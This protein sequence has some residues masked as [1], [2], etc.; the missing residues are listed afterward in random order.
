MMSDPTVTHHGPAAQCDVST[1]DASVSNQQCVRKSFQTP[2][3]S[4]EDILG[5]IWGPWQNVFINVPRI[6]V[7]RKEPINLSYLL[8]LVAL[9]HGFFQEPF[10]FSG[11]IE[12]NLNSAC[13]RTA[14]QTVSS[15]SPA[16]SA[17]DEWGLSAASR[18]RRAPSY[19]NTKSEF[20]PRR[21]ADVFHNSLASAWWSTACN[22]GSY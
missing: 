16:R 12:S 8:R 19:H 20:C 7:Q 17:E 14:V 9:V 6:S 10:V 2:I 1:V 13:E 15:S 3:M 21:C 5:H 11:A 4:W 22:S 18:G